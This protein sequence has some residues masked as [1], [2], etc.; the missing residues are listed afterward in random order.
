M[1]APCHGCQK[2]QPGCHDRCGDYQQFKAH[3]EAVNKME[4]DKKAEEALRF[5]GVQRVKHT[6]ILSRSE[7]RRRRP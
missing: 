6:S 2:R 4:R 1:D 7:R 5:E 3:R